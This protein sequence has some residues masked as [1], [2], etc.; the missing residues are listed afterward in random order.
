[1]RILQTGDIHLG[2]DLNG[3]SREAE[4]RIWLDRIADI[5]EAKEIDA[6]LITG[7]IYDN[8][9]PSGDSQKMFYD[10]IVELRRRRPSVSVVAIA[11]NHDPA[12]RFQ[13][14]GAILESLNAHVIGL[15]RRQEGRLMADR[16][17][18]PLR[19][20][21]GEIR[22]WAVAIPFLR[23]SDLPGLSF[24]KSDEG[25]NPVERAVERFLNELATELEGQ[26]DGLP[27]IAMAHMHCQGAMESEGAERHILIGGVHAVDV[28]VF[29]ACFAYV[30][31]GHIHKPQTLKGGR[32]RYSGS[33]FPLSVSEVGH[34]HGVTLIDIDGADLK[35]EHLPVP[36]PARFLRLPEEGLMDIS[37]L[38]DTLHNLD[39]DID[40]PRDLH[41]LVQ[42]NLK[43]TGPAS[44]LMAGAGT[45]LDSFPVRTAGVRVLREQPAEA[46]HDKGR[47]LTDMKPMDLFI[48]AFARANLND[49]EPRHIA[50]FSE[51]AQEN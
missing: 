28:D 19:D 17:L 44:V 11:G 22:A 7:D 26:T 50:A 9:N 42:V 15:V 5:V 31:L 14:P 34:E 46:Q 39:L 16:M 24:A 48:P 51:A 1:M 40:L 49:P 21:A 36:R 18:M 33:C 13:A 45:I 12:A 25:D 29:P 4:H 43:A 38:E 27:V 3:H 30:A 8:V 37:E 32:A 6:V 20:T 47:R 2:I 41:P 10:F 35:V 23:A